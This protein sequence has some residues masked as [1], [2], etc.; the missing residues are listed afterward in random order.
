MRAVRASFGVPYHPS[1]TKDVR[2]KIS[3]ICL[4][5][6]ILQ[7]E[8]THLF[9]ISEKD[10]W[11]ILEAR[12]GARQRRQTIKVTQHVHPLSQESYPIIKRPDTC[13]PNNL[14]K[15]GDRGLLSAG[16][17]EVV[18]LQWAQQTTMIIQEDTLNYLSGVKRYHGFTNT[19][20]G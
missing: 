15:A 17:I 14:P 4:A 18:S 19:S 3:T 12:D 1:Q 5:T 11:L 13:H 7:T 10:L 16:A 8:S 20:L 9:T 2:M 6:E